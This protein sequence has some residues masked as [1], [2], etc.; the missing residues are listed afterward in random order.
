MRSVYAPIQAD[1]A[2]G[3]LAEL[4]FCSNLQ[5]SQHPTPHAV[6]AVVLGY[7]SRDTDPLAECAAQVASCYGKDPEGTCERMRWARSVAMAT[8]AARD[9]AA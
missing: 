1:L 9:A 7:L 8:F 3:E 6:R 2:V 5:P 4:V